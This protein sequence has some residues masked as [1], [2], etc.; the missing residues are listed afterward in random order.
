MRLEGRLL[1]SGVTSNTHGWAL[2]LEDLEKLVM[3]EKHRKQKT[4]SKGAE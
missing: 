2:L 4:C 1:F 3:G